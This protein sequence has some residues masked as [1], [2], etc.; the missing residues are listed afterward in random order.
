MGDNSGSGAWIMAAGFGPG[1]AGAGLTLV[2]LRGPVI[3]ALT[4]LFVL[5]GPAICVHLLLPGLDPVARGT[6]AAA[7]SVVLS[8]GLAQLMI[9]ASL[10]S[11]RGGVAVIMAVCAVL[12]FAGVALD[13]SHGERVDTAERTPR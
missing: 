11:V 12:L 8:T 5:V 9:T 3:G 13:R 7:A 10:W 1:L 2:G 6:T 4:L